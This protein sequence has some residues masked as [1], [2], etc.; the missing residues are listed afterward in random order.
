MSTDSII[1]MLEKS[2]YTIEAL[3]SDA[4]TKLTQEQLKS[5]V[6]LLTKE[7]KEILVSKLNDEYESSDEDDGCTEGFQTFDCIQNIADDGDPCKFHG[8][9]EDKED[10]KCITI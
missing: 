9:F 3:L 4:D 7:Q 8:P 6:L 5:I 10:K 1:K 2:E